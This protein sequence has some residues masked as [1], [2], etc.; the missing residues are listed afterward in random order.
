MG[1]EQS[2]TSKNERKERT[3]LRGVKINDN[4]N[5]IKNYEQK[6]IKSVRESSTTDIVNYDEIKTY[7]DITSSA[8]QQLMR[9]GKPFTKK[10]MIAI[11]TALN[12]SQISHIK[13]LDSLTVTDLIS[14]I[15]C[16]IY[17]INRYSD[18]DSLSNSRT[19]TNTNMHRSHD[20]NTVRQLQSCRETRAISQTQILNSTS[21]STKGRNKQ[22]AIMDSNKINSS[23]LIVSNGSR[24]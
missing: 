7:L 2:K 15:R 13:T 17:D 10:D 18:S 14:M 21:D 1:S 9:D 5:N 24:I 16:M 12:P 4:I 20:S 8:T 3:E 11:I 22:L 19:A 23:Q 6:I